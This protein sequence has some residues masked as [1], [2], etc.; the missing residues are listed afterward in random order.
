MLVGTAP[1]SS[2]ALDAP[3]PARYSGA[4][5]DGFDRMLAHSVERPDTAPSAGGSD[6]RAVRSPSTRDSTGTNGTD[7]DDD[8]VR[9]ARAADAGRQRDAMKRRER[10]D[11]ADSADE[12]RS[13]EHRK[14]RAGADDADTA[15]QMA[16][17]VLLPFQLRP[18]A[19]GSADGATG[20]GRNGDPAGAAAATTA[21]ATGA[22]A[23]LAGA[24][25]AH[26]QE[27]AAAAGEAGADQLQRAAEQAAEALERAQSG[28]TQQGGN[29]SHGSAAMSG[30]GQRLAKALGAAVQVQGDSSPSEQPAPVKSDANAA[31]GLSSA[32][33]RDGAARQQD[34]TATNAV[35]VSVPPAAG[36]SPHPATADTDGSP[37]RQSRDFASSDDPVNVKPAP[38]GLNASAQVFM[39]PPVAAGVD[40]A[41]A[42]VAA[43][44]P[45][46]PADVPDA[47]SAAALIDTI[48]L[49]A[50]PGVWEAKVTLKPEHMG[51]V[52]IDLSVEHNNVTAVVRAES[53]RVREW[54]H[55][56]ESGVRNGLND[57]GLNLA[58]FDVEEPEPDRRRDEP[59]PQ[60]QEQRR[61]APRRAGT[62]ETRFEITV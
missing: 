11:A 33:G 46:A 61:K 38:E 41:A 59:P 2:A 19:N 22:D 24:S 43:P 29:D 9:N 49:N 15:M 36:S 51:E 57:Q 37:D 30:A 60:Q 52:T 12:A 28:G 6:R 55:S 34:M 31:A 50:K 17:G 39:V 5:E 40:K 25:A 56:N 45:A 26:E 3:S 44:P 7:R 53:A 23:A 58:R 21:E 4:G 1:K 48:R 10:R 16:M 35:A 13:D 54:L 8:A 62:T 27:E 47:D 42:P 18:V 20:A 32:A 14:A